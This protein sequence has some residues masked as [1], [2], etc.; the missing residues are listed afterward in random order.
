MKRRVQIGTALSAWL[1][2]PAVWAAEGEQ[3]NLFAGDIG[4]VVWTL[5]I[6]LLVIFI[7]GRFAWGPLLESLQRREEFIRR[8]L[9]EAKE[10]REAAEARLEEYEK[11]L[12]V[13][14]SEAAELVD[15]GR[16]E[17]QSVRSRIEDQAR[18][19]SDKMIER[20]RREIDLAKQTAIKDVYAISA[21][22]ATQIAGRILRRELSAKDHERLIGESIQELGKLEKN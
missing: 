7:L 11:K 15:Q 20:A 5:A 14:S 6:F 10:D 19:E 18:E 3:T 2:A 13:A 9:A 21:E 17:A 4:N 8:S 16:R 1:L 22:L 12:A